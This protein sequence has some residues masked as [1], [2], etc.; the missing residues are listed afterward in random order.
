MNNTNI[1][2]NNESMSE[3][4][5]GSETDDREEN[6]GD[7]QKNLD[8]DQEQEIAGADFDIINMTTVVFDD[9]SDD[10]LN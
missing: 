10:D 7:I 3:D 9:K 2:H 1:E 6:F 8:N 4:S 5:S